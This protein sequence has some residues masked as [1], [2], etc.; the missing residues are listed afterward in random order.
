M[1]N[2][3]SWTLLITIALSVSSHAAISRRS[4]DRIFSRLNQDA[5]AVLNVGEFA[6]MMGETSPS[7]AGFTLR[8]YRE[9]F[10]ADVDQGGI[11]SEEFFR[12][13]R[14]ETEELAG[15]AIE[16]FLRA[17]R[18]NDKVLDAKELSFAYKQRPSNRKVVAE[19]KRLDLDN[20]GKLSVKEFFQFLPMECKTFLGMK[21]N[22]ADLL[23]S[24]FGVSSFIWREDDIAYPYDPV[25]GEPQPLFFF[26]LNGGVITDCLM[27]FTILE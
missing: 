14:G 4:S 16:R 19:I 1:K 5:D 18:N 11:T 21:R 8:T 12:W 23:M 22:D 2:I 3:P 20:D 27:R 25:F 6:R 9:F 7:L 26:G 10:R 17:D 15:E 24:A 13:M